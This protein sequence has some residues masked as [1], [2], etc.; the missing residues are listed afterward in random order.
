MDDRRLW[1][2]A[3]LTLL[4]AQLDAIRAEEGIQ[5]SYVAFGR[6]TMPTALKALKGRNIT[7]ASLLEVAD[8]LDADVVVVKRR[9]MDG[10]A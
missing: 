10:A 8:S 3:Q 5:R 2:E 1:I 9:K 7:V 6:V 4:G